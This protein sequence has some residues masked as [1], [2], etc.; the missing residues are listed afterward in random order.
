MEY[1]HTR[2]TPNILKF[3]SMEWVWNISTVECT[4][5]FHT[6]PYLF[7]TREYGIFP[8]SGDTKYIKICKYGIS[9]EYFHSRVSQNYSILIPYSGVWNISIVECHKIIPYLFHTR[10]YGISPYSGDTKYIK[11]CKY[12]MSMEYF[13]SRVYKIIPYSSILIPYSGV[14]NISILGWH[15]IY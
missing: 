11:I 14:W 9:M 12:G 13:H 10:E 7:H 3:A 6:R 4:K 15:Q 2:V 8:Y 1:L 5:L